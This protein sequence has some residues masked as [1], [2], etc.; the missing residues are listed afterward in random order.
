[1][2]S[3]IEEY[4]PLLD[5]DFPRMATKIKSASMLII[6]VIISLLVIGVVLSLMKSWR[7]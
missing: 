2:T 3:F 1:M 6:V 7:R 4:I 5:I